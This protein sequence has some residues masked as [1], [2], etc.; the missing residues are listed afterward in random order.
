MA[1]VYSVA[2]SRGMAFEA[3]R[4]CFNVESNWLKCPSTRAGWVPC[5]ADKSACLSCYFVTDP[6]V[7]CRNISQSGTNSAT[8]AFASQRR[9]F[10]RSTSHLCAYADLVQRLLRPNAWLTALVENASRALQAPYIGM[11]LRTGDKSSEAPRH[12]LTEYLGVLKRASMVTG[13]RQ[14]VFAGT[15]SKDEQLKI[16]SGA[17]SFGVV[18]TPTPAIGGSLACPANLLVSFFADVMML[19]RS[20]YFIGTLSSNVGRL[21]Y[22]LMTARQTGRNDCQLPAGHDMDNIFWFVGGDGVETS[23]IYRLQDHSWLGHPG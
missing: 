15:I 12:S 3:H 6:P 1:S 10:W 19:S 23:N 20:E 7:R 4:V 13:L 11:H 21:I 17:R 14:V 2:L 8:F 5:A 22:E 9:G 18:A 16:V